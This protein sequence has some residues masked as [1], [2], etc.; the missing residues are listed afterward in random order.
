MKDRRQVR[1][2]LKGQAKEE[3]EEL[4]RI[5]G[6][7]QAKGITNSEEIQLLKSIEQKAVLIK[8]NPTYGD[9]IPKKLIPK[10]LD[11]SNLF[12][13]ELTGRWRMLYSLEGNQIEIIAF[14]L[15]VLNHPEYDRLF[16]Y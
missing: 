3:F 12:R 4:N 7:Q 11:V 10:G 9:N 15:Y 16:G 8:E 2:I 5:A 14:V 6:G 1:V 13:V